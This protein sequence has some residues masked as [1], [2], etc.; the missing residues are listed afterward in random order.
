MLNNCL[1]K[2]WAKT[3]PTV[4]QSTCEAEFIGANV[5]GKEALGYANMLKEIGMPVDGGIHMETDASAAIGVAKRSGSE[6]LG[7]FMCV[8]CGCKNK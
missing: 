2:G 6:S 4:A 1:V 5:G 7:I 3:Q 8:F